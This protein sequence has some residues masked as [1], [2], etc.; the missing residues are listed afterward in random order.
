MSTSTPVYY[1]GRLYFGI[2]AGYDGGSFCRFLVADA[3]SLQTIASVQALGDVKASP[4]L[5]TDT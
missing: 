4:L 2:G 3:S 1:K 5:S